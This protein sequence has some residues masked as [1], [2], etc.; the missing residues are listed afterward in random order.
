MCRWSERDVSRHHRNLRSRAR[1]TKPFLLFPPN[2]YVN[3]N[4]YLIAR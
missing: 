3:I 1:G 4:D 2:D